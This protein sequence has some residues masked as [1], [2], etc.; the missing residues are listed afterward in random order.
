MRLQVISSNSTYYFSVTNVAPA[1]PYLQ[2]SNQY[3]PLTTATRAGVKLK[4]QSGNATY[5]ALVYESG[6]YNT[7]S[8]IPG[9]MSSTTALTRASTYSYATAES[10]VNY[11][12]TVFTR[13]TSK[14]GDTLYTGFNLAY[15][16]EYI[17]KYT[18]NAWNEKVSGNII[19]EKDLVWG[20]GNYTTMAGNDFNKCSYKLTVNNSY[21]DY[22]LYTAYSAGGPQPNMIVWQTQTNVSPVKTTSFFTP[23]GRMPYS[24]SRWTY[25]ANTLS[26]TSTS[27]RYSWTNWNFDTNASSASKNITTKPTGTASTITSAS[28]VYYGNMFIASYT[29]TR[30]VDIPNFYHSSYPAWVTVTHT[31]LEHF[32]YQEARVADVVV[33]YSTKAVTTATLTTSSIYGYSGKLSSSR[34]G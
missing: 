15:D 24:N 4:V 28:L 5:R 9:S 11:N 31:K 1:K 8:S 26:A 14:I 16:C 30:E 2:I 20:A 22:Y 17:G 18:I 6:Y 25:Y 19:I 34:W 7:T 13:T 12:T 27:S 33:T 32:R 10:R 29:A 21:P 23:A 3:L